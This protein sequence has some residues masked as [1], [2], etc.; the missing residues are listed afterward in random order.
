M[1]SDTILRDQNGL[2]EEEFLQ[3]YSSDAFPKPSLTVDI[4]IFRKKGNDM[5]LLMIRRKGHPFMGYLALP[6][7]FAE[8]GETVEKS[9]AREL[10][11]E[12]GLTDQALKLTGVYSTPGRDP[13]GWTVSC[14]FASLVDGDRLSPT[15]GDDAASV[16]W[17][18]LQR[19]TDGNYHLMCGEQFAFDHRQIVRDAVRIILR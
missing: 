8:P 3:Q 17:I 12:T 1:A 4:L 19:G 15:A 14:A 11:E 18:P 10:Y 5:H 9:A 7:G 6:G 2:T 16:H 13:R